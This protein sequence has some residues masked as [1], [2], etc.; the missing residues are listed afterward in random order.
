MKAPCGKKCPDRAAECKLTCEKWKEYEKVYFQ[1]Q[2]EKDKER[3]Q[4][5]N[6]YN[7]KETQFEH[8]RKR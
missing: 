1:E 8:R 3:E 2:R 7:F 5:Y 6:Y 4:M